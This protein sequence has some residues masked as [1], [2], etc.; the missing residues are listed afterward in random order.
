[1]KSNCEIEI[2]D[3]SSNLSLTMFS[4]SGLTTYVCDG[5]KLALAKMPILKI[6]FLFSPFLVDKSVLMDWERD[7][8]KTSLKQ[9][10]ILVFVIFYFS[11]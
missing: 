8:D 10:W 2:L 1:M 5:H 6:I 7:R 4:L 9:N 3:K 11:F